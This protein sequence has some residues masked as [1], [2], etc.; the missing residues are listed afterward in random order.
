MDKMY[1]S[2][3]SGYMK[4]LV[5]GIREDLDPE[6]FQQFSRLGLT[7]ILAISGLH[8]A[9]F[10]Y[11]L[12]A[13][14]RFLRMTRERI[15]VTLMLAVPFYVMLSGAS[16]SVLRAG[17]MAV[18]ALLAARMDKL[19]DGLHILAAAAVLMLIWDPFYIG[20]VSFQLSFI[21]T[22]GLILG[23][24]PVRKAMPPWRK[25]KALLDLLAVTLVAQAASFPVSIYYFNQ[26][27]L[28]SL[29]ANFFLVPFISFIVMPIGAIA[30]GIGAL[31]PLG[32]KLLA[33]VSVYA[34]DW[35]FLFVEKLSQVEALRTIW[36]TPPLWWIVVWYMLFAV[37]FRLLPDRSE[38]IAM[39]D[40]R[41]ELEET[42]PLGGNDPATVPLWGSPPSHRNGSRI[43][44]RIAMTASCTAIV[45]LLLY[46]YYPDR[47]DHIG[48]VHILDV[49]QGDA[50]YIRTP[51]GKRILI[52]GGGTLSFRKPGEEWKE[53][54]DPFEVGRKVIVPLLMKRGVH[55]IDLL[56]ISHLDSDHIRGLKAIMDTIPVKKIL[57][58]GSI[59]YVD[60][61]EDLLRQAVELHIPL[62]R[63]EAGQQWMVDSNT[64][65]TVLW[66]KAPQVEIDEQQDEEEVS[67][68]EDQNESSVVLH[69]QMYEHTF[70]LTGDIGK[71]T[72]T[73]IN[74]L[75]PYHSSTTACCGYADVLKIAHHG[76]RYS[77]SADWLNRWKPF[78]AVVSVGATNTYGHPHPDVIGRL[79]TA[80]S[81]LLRTD[82]N[83]EVSYKVSREGLYV[84]TVK[85]D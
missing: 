26:F 76:S 39:L 41:E 3:Q 4:G 8:V 31:W 5:L 61:A 62:Y 36:A 38:R 85:E 72:E 67:E 60:D 70:L 21:V 80:K 55:E 71:A 52:D 33:S 13:V 82:Q 63:A 22:A 59:K 53:R 10:I 20:D 42:L 65:L 7:H 81:E 54:S 28:L 18:L 17:I 79:E 77:T 75:W 66:P 58:N 44:F 74:R 57:W 73:S 84:R 56:V 64:E 11:V 45:M 27:H 83:G 14:L 35:T 15:L 43:Y 37:F 48:K 30:L 9:V 23:V 34:N 1:P 25:G 50:I 51:G 47:F 16:P 69:L 49:G 2:E 46:A 29:P 12:G 19:K 78:N 32:G 24:P 6:Q 40:A 68:M